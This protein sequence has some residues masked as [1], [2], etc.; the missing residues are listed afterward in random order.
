ME[1]VGDAGLPELS[2]EADGLHSVA[3]G[4]SSVG[5]VSANTLR[6]VLALRT[7]KAQTP[8]ALDTH[9]VAHALVELYP[10]SATISSIF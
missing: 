5:L 6:D 1:A 2:R 10:T 9:V 7:V 8:P 3:Y 4:V